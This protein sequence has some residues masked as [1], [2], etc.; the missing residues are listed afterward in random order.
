MKSAGFAYSK[1][2]WEIQMV[3]MKIILLTIPM[4]ALS[5]RR[6]MVFKCRI[7]RFCLDADYIHKKKFDRHQN[8]L[9]FNNKRAGY[10]KF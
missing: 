5:E 9:A 6:N 2:R 8:C 4:A 1:N 3:F 7:C 10:F